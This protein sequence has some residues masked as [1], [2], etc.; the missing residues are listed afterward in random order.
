MRF[1]QWQ[2]L[3]NGEDNE[4]DTSEREE[5]SAVQPPPNTITVH[6][7]FQ[8]QWSGVESLVFFKIVGKERMVHS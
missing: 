1:W 3:L 2:G 6:D 5:I 8:Q 7:K 4:D